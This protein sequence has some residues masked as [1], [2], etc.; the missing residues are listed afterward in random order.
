MANV[1]Q[2][3]NLPQRTLLIG[4]PKHGEYMNLA[5]DCEEYNF[6]SDR[7][8]SPGRSWNDYPQNAEHRYKFDSQ[9]TA[10]YNKGVYPSDRISV[11]THHV[12]W[13]TP[14]NGGFLSYALSEANK[15]IL[16]A[17]A[18]LQEKQEIVKE[19]NKE[20]SL[21]AADHKEVEN[22]LDDATHRL[23]NLRSQLEAIGMLVG[24]AMT[25]TGRDYDPVRIAH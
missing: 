16:E 25:M 8:L 14:D 20:L 23:K 9:L 1:E 2:G 13:E 19:R 11:F 4:G 22:A 21:L 15:A 5:A 18:K 24:S 17:D 10:E 3:G 12:L 7:M 6:I